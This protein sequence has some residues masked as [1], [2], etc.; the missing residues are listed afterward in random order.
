MAG[1]VDGIMSPAVAPLG[2]PAVYQHRVATFPHMNGVV[3]MDA[4][5]LVA[6]DVGRVRPDR[7]HGHDALLRLATSQQ[8]TQQQGY[9]GVF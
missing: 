3:D 4:V 7:F 8:Y 1:N 2:V 9:D 5:A 6:G